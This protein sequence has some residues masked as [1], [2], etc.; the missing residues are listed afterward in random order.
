MRE[1]EA[2]IAAVRA[3]QGATPIALR[4]LVRLKLLRG[5]LPDDC[6]AVTIA[7]SPG[8]ES[9]CGACDRAVTSREAMIV[10]VRRVSPVAAPHEKGPIRFHTDCFVIWNEERA[11][12]PRA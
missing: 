4:R 10:V 7:E 9:P 1:A 8:D 3:M 6:A 11:S 12:T 5:H 2:A